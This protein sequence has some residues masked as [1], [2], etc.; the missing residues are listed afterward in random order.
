[1]AGP[2]GDQVLITF[3]VTPAQASKLESRDLDYWKQVLTGAP[4]ALSLPTDRAITVD[5]AL[6]APVLADDWAAWA[7]LVLSPSS[8]TD[9]NDFVPANSEGCS[10]QQ[11]LPCSAS[12][13]C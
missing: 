12:R 7:D 10:A 11:P 2:T 3:T 9:P 4:E 8:V 13:S 5:T 6:R 1:M